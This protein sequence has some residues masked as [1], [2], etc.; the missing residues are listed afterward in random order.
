MSMP[1][2]KSSAFAA[3]SYQPGALVNGA[4]INWGYPVTDSANLLDMTP[5]TQT[6]DD[7]PVLADR[8]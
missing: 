1:V 3:G 7:S 2:E 4:S 8:S 6:A 5:W